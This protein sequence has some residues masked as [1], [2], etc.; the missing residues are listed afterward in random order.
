MLNLIIP[1][2]NL[3]TTKFDNHYQTNQKLRTVGYFNHEHPIT[4]ILSFY[5]ES[6]LPIQ[7]KL[8]PEDVLPNKNGLM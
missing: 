6:N 5:Q 1:I 2:Y 7:S 8:L 4:G 3:T